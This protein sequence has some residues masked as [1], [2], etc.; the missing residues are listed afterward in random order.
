MKDK[1]RIRH[2]QKGN[3][4]VGHCGATD[5]C[6]RDISA[7]AFHDSRQPSFC[8]ECSRLARQAVAAQLVEEWRADRLKEITPIRSHR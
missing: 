7:K 6:F 5:D 8:P 4:R 1:T 2:W 3:V